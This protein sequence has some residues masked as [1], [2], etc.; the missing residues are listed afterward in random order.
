MGGELGVESELG[1]GSTFWFT[2]RFKRATGLAGEPPSPRTELQGVKVLLVDDNATNLNVLKSLVEGWGMRCDCVTSGEAALERLRLAAESD[3]YQAGLLDLCMPGM[4]GIELAR[5]IKADGATASTRL[6]ILTSFGRD[7]AA[8]DALEAGVLRFLNKPVNPARLY[9]CLAGVMVEPPGGPFA[10][11][12]ELPEAKLRFE[13]AILVAEDNPVNQDVV[14]HMLKILGCSVEIAENGVEVVASA[15][16]GGFDLI[17]MDCQMPLMDG[18][19]ASGAIR[20]R[21]AAK[22]LGR[23][24]IV[25]L[26]ANAIAGD[27]ERCLAAGMDDYL[28][29]PFDLGQLRL[30]LQRWIPGKAVP[31]GS[32]S[33]P[34]AGAPGGSP[35]DHGTVFDMD[36]LL[37]RLGDGEY[38]HMFVNKFIDST[39]KLMEALSGSIGE[40]NCEAIHLQSHSIKG[41]ASSIGAEAMRSIAAQMEVAAKGGEVSGHPALHAELEQA[42]KAFKEAAPERT[43]NWNQS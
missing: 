16:K 27:R 25:A 24:P 23:L 14:E 35:A 18:F 12:G 17:F 28:S 2:A 22:G 42:F 15:E 13:A 10:G 40:G 36:G 6:V 4:D 3:P 1:K 5:A 33:V 21:E 30:V 32:A 31:G 26:T 7:G 43:I 39:T 41:A 9:D 11:N 20:D 29:K 8:R 19:A 34:R 38:M 37:E